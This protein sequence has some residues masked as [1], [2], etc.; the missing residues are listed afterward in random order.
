VTIATSVPT[1]LATRMEIA[2]TLSTTGVAM[3]ATFVRSVTN[4]TMDRANQANRSIAMITRNALMI[5]VIPLMD[6]VSIPP[7]G[8]H[9]TIE[10]H[11]R[12]MSTV[13]MVLARAE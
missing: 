6:I 13:A 9:V 12:R 5:L 8:G 1:I 11:A 10:I 4:V 2:N 3:M 7:I